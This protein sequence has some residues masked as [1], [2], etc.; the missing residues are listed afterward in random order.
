MIM[1]MLKSKR[2]RFRFILL[3][4]V[5][6][7]FLRVGFKLCVCV[8]VCVFRCALRCMWSNSPVVKWNYAVRI[9]CG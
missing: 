7:F 6:W 8:Y 1:L 4:L 2:P 9:V 5:V 3:F